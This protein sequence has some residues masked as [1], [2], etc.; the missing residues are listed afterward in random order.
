M[1]YC[2]LFEHVPSF[3]SM[4]CERGDTAGV[5]KRRIMDHLA[6]LFEIKLHINLSLLFKEVIQG[7]KRIL[8]TI[9]S[10]AILLLSIVS[11][12]AAADNQIFIGFA[13]CD[14]SD[15]WQSYF[16]DALRNTAE[17]A[18]ARI[19]VMDGRNDSS[20]QIADVENLISQGADVIITVLVDT[21]TTDPVIN[22]CKEANI[23]L[24]GAVR[25][26]DGADVFVGVDFTR[27]AIDQATK[28]ANLIGGKG[29]IGL[30]MGTMGNDDQI[31]RT[32]GNKEA[33]KNFPDVKIIVEDSG[34]WD[35]ANALSIVENW[36]QTGNQFDAILSNNDEMA[37]GAIRA[38]EAEGLSD[39]VVVAGVD[40][41]PD[42]LKLVSSGALDLTYFFNPFSLADK[43]IDYSI[44]L[45]KGGSIPEKVTLLDLE[46]ITIENY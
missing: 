19:V 38:L 42:A 43:V 34:Q 13:Q 10:T 2:F 29:N 20:K 31:K 27:M 40:G 41:T 30:L 3:E 39:K 5:K 23:P 17:N 16:T 4:V 9:L 22:A 44:T 12:C 14:L 46:P 1:G 21:T 33:L 45:A 11:C 18:G 36:L 25:Q 24:I 26:F 6:R 7:M 32:D 15:T 37:I 28:T 8:V 35:R